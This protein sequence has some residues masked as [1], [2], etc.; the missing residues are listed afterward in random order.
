MNN[1]TSCAPCGDSPLSVASN[2]VGLLTFAVATI[3]TYLAYSTLTLN[4][5]DEIESHIQNLDGLREELIPLLSFC[6]RARREDGEAFRLHKDILEI[7]LRALLSSAEG[8]ATNLRTLPRL[9]PN[10]FFQ[11]QVRRRL[12]WLRMRQLFVVQS[13]Q[14]AA[15]KRDMML[16][17][18]SLLTW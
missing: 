14:I 17:L 6:D 2:I 3:A 9:D 4:V 10:R 7:K 1:T 13:E 18:L 8:L 15:M 5:P 11:F 16:T 12:R